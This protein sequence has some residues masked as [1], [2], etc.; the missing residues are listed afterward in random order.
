VGAPSFASLKP[1][2]NDKSDCGRKGWVSST[3]DLYRS[4]FSHSV[5]PADCGEILLS[6]PTRCRRSYTPCARLGFQ[7]TYRSRPR[8]FALKSYPNRVE[9]RTNCVESA[10]N[11]RCRC[12]FSGHLI[13][14]DH[15]DDFSR[16]AQIRRAST[17]HRERPAQPEVER[18]KSAKPPLSLP[19]MS[20]P[21]QIGV[22]LSNFG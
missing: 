9:S 1:T 10:S 11:P 3:L 14:R 22:G 12:W 19:S 17:C 4:V 16:A 18:P 2:W 15:R 13:T 5:I 8:E 20:I 21:P 7:R 6:D